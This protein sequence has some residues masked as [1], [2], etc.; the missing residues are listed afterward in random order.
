MFGM[1]KPHEIEN[2]RSPA[3]SKSHPCLIFRIPVCLKPAGG[4]GLCKPFSRRILGILR[5]R[6]YAWPSPQNRMSCFCVLSVFD[7]L[8]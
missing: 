6:N 3:T 4:G 2:S 8:P 7:L 5:G 1:R